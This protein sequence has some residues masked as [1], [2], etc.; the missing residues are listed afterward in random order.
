MRN[1]HNGNNYNGNNHNRNNHNNNNNFPHQNIPPIQHFNNPITVKSWNLNQN[2]TMIIYY[3]VN[4][5]E[6]N[7]TDI[8]C[9]Q[10]FSWDANSE[11]LAY[12]EKEKVDDNLFHIKF[13]GK[14]I[15]I[16]SYNVGISS[17]YIGAPRC[18]KTEEH[19]L[20]IVW[21][22]N[23]FTFVNT[24]EPAYFD[25][26]S[27]LG[28]RTSHIAMLCTKELKY[29]MVMNV[30]G[31][32]K[33]SK[34]K[35]IL[36]NSIFTQLEHCN[37]PTIITGD[38]N[39]RPNELAPLVPNKLI[40]NPVNGTTHINTITDET[41]CIDH[42][43]HNS[44]VIINKIMISGIDQQSQCIKSEMK[45]KSHDHGILSFQITI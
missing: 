21:N 18:P 28:N 8:V 22:P 31:H 29:L 10:E 13:N 20:L 5:T 25:L 35:N 24:L 9:L 15:G 33:N 38:F 2:A 42:V 45:K 26:P 7:A 34:K 17:P 40:F 30:H 11:Y 27:E 6:K 14:I 41:Y 36:F 44:F 43:I 32:A 23:V 3:V 1:N 4:G 16:F 12:F 19:G 37:V 39:Y